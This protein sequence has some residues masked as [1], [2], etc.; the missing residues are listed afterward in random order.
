M[1]IEERQNSVLPFRESRVKTR[2][3]VMTVGFSSY[4]FAC[5]KCI[6]GKSW[7]E[8]ANL[9]VSICCVM[10]IKMDSRLIKGGVV[11]SCGIKT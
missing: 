2:V 3:R 8:N 10:G 6:H 1:N 5:L 11:N 7:T 4:S 9:C